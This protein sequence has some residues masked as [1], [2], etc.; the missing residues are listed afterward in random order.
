MLAEL[1]DAGTRLVEQTHAGGGDFTQVV[2]RH[3]GGHAHGDAGGAVEQQVGQTRRQGR[4]FV[5]GA[6]E[7][8]Y[9]VHRALP[10]LGQ[11]HLGIA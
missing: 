10:Q 6:V 3:V 11:Q 5:E 7:V 2:R 4:R 1:L 9:P 8:R